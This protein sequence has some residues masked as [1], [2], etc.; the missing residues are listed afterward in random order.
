MRRGVSRYLEKLHGYTA[1]TFPPGWDPGPYSEFICCWELLPPE[2]HDYIYDILA[3]IADKRAASVLSSVSKVWCRCF[4]PRLFAGLSLWDE[5]DSRMLYSIL[6]S[7]LSAWLA[8]HVSTL[9]FRMNHFPSRPL[10]IALLRL[11]PACRCVLHTPDFP[12]GLISHSAGMKSSLRDLTSLDLRYCHFPSFRTLLRVLADITYLEA[13]RLF[14]VTWSGDAPVAVEAA[15]NI[16]SGSFSRVREVQQVNCT[17]NLA[18]PAWILAAASTQHSFT[19]RRTA[20]PAVPAETW[21]VIE[22]I[23]MFLPSDDTIK[24]ARFDVIEAT[25]RKT[26][27][28]LQAASSYSQNTLKISINS[29]VFYR[30]RDGTL[31]IFCVKLLSLH[32]P[33]AAVGLGL[34]AELPSPT[35]KTATDHACTS[36]LAIG[37]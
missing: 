25:Q 9:S 2:L 14:D 34:F 35:G 8:E 17:S 33:T 4:R 7:P 5:D 30:S 29:L 32:L 11:L 12:S 23:Q 27:L 18:V 20:G 13:V 16:C 26:H 15:N 31:R 1:H 37:P 24:Y 19:R 3:L 10:W 21:A 6:Q 36:S 22:L 28:S